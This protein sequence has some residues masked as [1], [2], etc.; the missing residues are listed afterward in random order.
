MVTIEYRD[1]VQEGDER[2]R[3]GP[4]RLPARYAQPEPPSCVARSLPAQTNCPPGTWQSAKGERTGYW[5]P[6]SGVRQAIRRGRYT[7]WRERR[8]LA[9]DLGAASGQFRPGHL[10]E[11]ADDVAPRSR[12]GRCSR[13]TSMPCDGYPQ[14]QLSRPCGLGIDRRGT[15]A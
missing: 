14:A 13:G 4:N 3:L 9:E 5:L 8:L 1:L 7:L 12:A 2:V 10:L 15:G 11:S 6:W